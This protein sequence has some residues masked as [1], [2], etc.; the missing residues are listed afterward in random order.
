MQKPAQIDMHV[1]P[2]IVLPAHYSV[3]EAH[4]L[5]IEAA[6]SHPSLS[7]LLAM[8]AEIFALQADAEKGES[9]SAALPLDKGRLEALY[10]GGTPWLTE[11]DL[12]LRA[13]EFALLVGH[14]ADALRRHR[15]DWAEDEIELS[16]EGLVALALRGLEER[17][18]LIREDAGLQS[19]A[20]EFALQAHLRQHAAQI[21]P[22]LDLQQWR[23]PSCPI[24][25]S[26]PA[27]ALLEPSIG[28]RSLFCQ[29]CLTSWPYPRVGCTFCPN[30]GP[31]NY[32][33]TGQ[34]GYRLYVCPIC[35]KYLK[36]IDLGRVPP[37]TNPAVQYLLTVG[38]D[39][40]AME[41]GYRPAG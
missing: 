28:A 5:L 29:R 26:P 19:A 36:T 6:A 1:E 17:R 7:P 2:E 18:S 8:H 32:H 12:R 20:V 22:V 39:F 15:L 9:A 24:C 10:H 33:D 30:D 13:D 38:L 23:R 35:Q 11:G 25:S 14:M 4:A 3:G 37:P 21:A 31:M 41:H 40:A 27:L 16:P 34:P